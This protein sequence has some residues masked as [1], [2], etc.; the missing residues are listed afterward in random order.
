MAVGVVASMGT[1]PPVLSEF[2]DYVERTEKIGRVVVL[3]MKEKMVRDSTPVAAAAV[4][5]RFP[6]ISRRS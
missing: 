4:S 5:E 6:H 1:S 3:S 2:V